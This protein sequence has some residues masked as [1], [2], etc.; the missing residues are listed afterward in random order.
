MRIVIYSTAELHGTIIF[1]TH[2]I[3]FHN[4][5]EN[6]SNRKNQYHWEVIKSLALES[7]E[8][9]INHL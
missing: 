1:K 7:C 8:V 6:I 5:T 2:L 9:H 3:C 4:E